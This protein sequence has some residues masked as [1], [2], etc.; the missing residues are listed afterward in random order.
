MNICNA[1]T[2]MSKSTVEMNSQNTNHH[3][4]AAAG[5]WN[6]NGGEMGFDRLYMNDYRMAIARLILLIGSLTLIAIN[7]PNSSMD[8]TKS[9][10]SEYNMYFYLGVFFLGVLITWTSLDGVLLMYK[11]KWML[12][13]KKQ[14]FVDSGKWHATEL[15][16]SVFNVLRLL[17]GLIIIVLSAIG[18]FNKM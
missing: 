17:T 5:L 1:L 10:E 16:V 12:D 8:N 7:M 18:M 2:I 15:V 3:S 14:K 11:G 6:I 4:R 13:G 9:D